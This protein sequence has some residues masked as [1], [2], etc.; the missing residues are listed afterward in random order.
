MIGPCEYGS[1]KMFSVEHGSG[2]NNG[3]PATCQ[4]RA[5][6]NGAD[7]NYAKELLELI[8]FRMHNYANST[9]YTSE[10]SVGLDCAASGI[11]LTCSLLLT[12]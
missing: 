6:D 9:S 2:E 12:A 3:S 1:V 5:L 4:G 7:R 11:H 10:N 8:C